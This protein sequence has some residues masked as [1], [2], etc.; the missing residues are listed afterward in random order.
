MGTLLAIVAVIAA[1]GSVIF[2]GWQTSISRATA[3]LQVEA[4]VVT[5]LDD[6]LFKAAGD[7]AFCRAVWG[8]HAEEDH[9]HV[10]PQAVANMLQVAHR[11]P[12]IAWV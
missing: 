9:T 1:V 7:P 10:A 12:S 11:R 3:E 4:A 2:A 5:R 6:L 8:E